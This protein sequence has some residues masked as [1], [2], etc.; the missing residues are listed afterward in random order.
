MVAP[1]WLA[2]FSPFFVGLVLSIPLV[3][4]GASRAV[5]LWLQQNGLCA[6][7]EELN[8]RSDVA[9]LLRTPVRAS[10]THMHGGIS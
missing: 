9:A 2:W 7:P 8:S 3:M 1:A 4:V 10:Q 5:G 6:M